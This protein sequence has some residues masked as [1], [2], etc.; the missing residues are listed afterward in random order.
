LIEE[1]AAWQDC[2][3]NKHIRAD[4]HFTSVD[5]RVKLKPLY[6]AI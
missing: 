4:W 1:V 6:P 5:A 2:R 3:N